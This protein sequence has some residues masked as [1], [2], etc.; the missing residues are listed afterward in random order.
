[1]LAVVGVGS[2]LQG[3]DSM[4]GWDPGRC[5]GLGWVAPL[6]LWVLAGVEF[7]PCEKQ[8]REAG[9]LR[10]LERMELLRRMSGEA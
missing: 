7:S 3:L 4:A 9:L 1:M 8:G 5:P 10:V 2:P 6:G